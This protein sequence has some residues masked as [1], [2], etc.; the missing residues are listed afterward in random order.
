[1]FK[2]A[3][4]AQLLRKPSWAQPLLEDLATNGTL[5]YF[6][7]S[8]EFADS[9]TNYY[10]AQANEVQSA[11]VAR[12]HSAQEVATVLKALRRHL[13]DSVPIAIRGA[14]HAT[15]AG[16]AKA[17]NGV[18]VDT[19]GLRGI[20]ILP[21]GVVRIGAG[22]E[23]LDVYTA[24]EAHE[25]PL[26]VAG[27]RAGRVGVAGFLLGGGISYFSSQYGFGADS[28]RTW[29]VVLANGDIIRA[30][31]EDP[32]TA[33]L[34]DAL[35]GGSTNFGIVTAVE[36]ACFPH[37]AHFRCSNL[38][39]LYPARQATLQALV[40][41]GSRPDLAVTHAIW[42]ITH[43]AGMPFKVINVMA[44]TTDP[45]NC[46]GLD[47]FLNAPGRVPLVG[48]LK[49]RKHSHFAKQV[50]NLSPKDG[51]R[52]INRSISFKLNSQFLNTAVD[53][54]Y[55]FVEST[56][57]VSGILNTLVFLALPTS[58]LQVSRD[59]SAPSFPDPKPTKNSQGLC[60]EDGP[61]AIME[62]C[63]T[64]RNADDDAFMIEK[65]TQFLR[66]VKLAAKEMGLE[67]CYIF[68]NY[69]W[70]QEHV[71]QS[72]GADRLAV[73]RRVASRW[74]PDGFFQYRVIGGYKINV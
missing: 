11:A 8:A 9:E 56:R 59:T 36:M 30:S 50:G 18:T 4:P 17:E 71:I 12:P 13:P 10:T 31:R 38:F 70:P 64:W 27:G 46:G 3:K 62:I 35:R 33:D 53:M 48:A 19:R 28:V 43:V 42:A 69:A 25:P 63:L 49:E 47:G 55:G 14:G 67:H 37:P 2:R 57:H 52:T 7:G 44:S 60:P 74:D 54:W 23:W 6:P 32:E 45:A 21:G 65:G 22:H 29:E 34:W 15:F 72:Y 61:L 39:Y 20:D 58:M 40:D 66:E 73:L 16:A 51:S 41:Q 5:I 24:L 26:T 1:M 68:P